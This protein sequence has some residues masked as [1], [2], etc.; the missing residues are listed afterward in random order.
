MAG[1]V[2]IAVG[3]VVGLGFAAYK[4]SQAARDFGYQME[5]VNRKFA[6]LS[7]AQAAIAQSLDVSRT[8]RDVKTG[9]NTAG[10]AGALGSAI[11]RFE[12]ASRPIEELS[13]NLKNVVG[14]SFMEI[15]A[16]LVS[17]ATP[18]VEYLNELLAELLGTKRGDKQGELFADFTQRVAA[19]QG[20]HRAQI[21]A[22]MQ[23]LRDAHRRR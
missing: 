8:F 11:D 14:G 1:P 17:V 23:R 9:D 12:E 13:N 19:E 6:G 20:V 2:A 10:T 7:A 21:E 16:E 22:N 18:A 4:A 15:I 3:A 5:G